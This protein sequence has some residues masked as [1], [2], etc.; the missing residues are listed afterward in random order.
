MQ[1]ETTKNIYIA[2]SNGILYTLNKSTLKKDWVFAGDGPIT[3][4][5]LV[6]SNYIYMAT[7]A[8]KLYILDKRDGI[9]IQEIDLDGRARSAPIISQGKLFL[10]CED[11][12][13]IAYVENR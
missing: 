1:Q 11:R 5:A 2:T 12:R 13:I 4:F 7:M 10:A 8:R 3:G 6:T 9:L